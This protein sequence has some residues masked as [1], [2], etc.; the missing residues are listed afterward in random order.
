VPFATV[1]QQCFFAW[2]NRIFFAHAANRVLSARRLWKRG[3]DN[4]FAVAASRVARWQIFKQKIPIWVHFGGPCNGRCWHII[5]T[6]G[7]FYFAIWYI[8]WPFG[9]FY[10]YLVY[11]SHFG[12]LFQEKSGN[13]G[14][15]AEGRYCKKVQQGPFQR[16]VLNFRP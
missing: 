7:L 13:P 1:W 16:P 6:L 8:L 10:G 11:F 9:I 12:R 15:A 2:I 4:L 3:E 14:C 5:C